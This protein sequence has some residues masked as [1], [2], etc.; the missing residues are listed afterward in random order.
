MVLE[1]PVAFEAGTCTGMAHIQEMPLVLDNDAEGPAVQ[2][3]VSQEQ[4]PSDLSYFFHEAGCQFTVVLA[5][6]MG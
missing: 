1:A 4:C 3:A 5:L 2:R 6:Q